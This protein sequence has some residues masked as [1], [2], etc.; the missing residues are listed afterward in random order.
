MLRITTRPRIDWQSAVEAKG[1]T[2]HTLDGIPYWDESAYY[3]FESSEIDR[4]EKATQQLH[5]MCIKAA[6]HIIESKRLDE[7]AIPRQ[8]HAFIEQSWERDERSIYGRFDLAYD[9]LGP[10]KMLEY[11]ADT[12]T[13]LLE[14]AVIQWF[15]FQDLLAPLNEMERASFDQFNSIHEALIEA[16]G[17]VRKQMGTHV[18][19]SGL[20]EPSED[21]MT[22]TYLRDT[23]IQ[24]GL[25]TLFLNMSEVGW[26]ARRGVFT[27]LHEYPI[28]ILFKLYPWEWMIHESFGPHLPAAPT[29]WLEPPWKMVLSNKAILPILWE[30]FPDNPYL[31]EAHFDPF[32]DDYVIKPIL[33][34]EGANI[35][36]IEGGEVVAETDGEYGEGAVVYQAAQRLPEFSGNYPVLGSWIVDGEARG[37]GIREDNSPITRNLSRFVPHLFR[38][39]SS[40]KPPTFG[41]LKKAHPASG[42][43][44]GGVWDKWMDA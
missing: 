6:G 40:A 30:M 26:N 43:Q 12:P 22:I 20:S 2:F 13:S 31:L 35:T 34:R 17:R 5:D 3:L 11:N 15:W 23:A 8:V 38:K 39:H 25:K 37:L 32:G 9:G 28:P 7:L 18:C 19:F 41:D 33:A 10:P 16:W 36:L 4:I 42:P 1:L 21:L 27:D 29:R 24:A 14:A 44:S